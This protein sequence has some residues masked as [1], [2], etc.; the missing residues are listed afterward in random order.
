MQRPGMGDPDST[1]VKLSLQMVCSFLPLLLVSVIKADVDQVWNTCV[2]S[3]FVFA[4]R[5]PE[6][7]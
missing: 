2:C 5:Y 1:L 4:R 6:V 7:A 3:R